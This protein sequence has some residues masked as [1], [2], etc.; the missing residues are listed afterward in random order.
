MSLGRTVFFDLT[1]AS[2]ALF[3]VVSKAAYP[4]IKFYLPSGVVGICPFLFSF[5]RCISTP[6]IFSF[7]CFSAMSDMDTLRGIC[8]NLEGP[9]E[10][11]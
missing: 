8:S 11:F 3:G 9:L 5:K 7:T 10:A 6:W 4:T 1:L 2:M